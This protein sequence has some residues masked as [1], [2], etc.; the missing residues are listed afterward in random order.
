MI[1][2]QIRYGVQLALNN[3]YNTLSMKLLC[4]CLG[5]LV[6]ITPTV[7]LTQTLLDESTRTNMI[8]AFQHSFKDATPRT[9]RDLVISAIDSGLITRGL[10]LADARLMFAEDLQ[11]LR[12]EGQSHNLKGVVFF[13]KAQP[14]PKNSIMSA[15]QQGWYIDLVFSADDRLEHYSLSNLHK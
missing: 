9:K 13:E 3:H 7:V 6:T 10:S 14:A 11:N 4:C 5:L 8:I 12:R 1:T 15:L 2:T